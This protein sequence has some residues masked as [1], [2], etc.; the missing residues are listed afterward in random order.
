MTRAG[1]G[2]LEA[3]D[4]VDVWDVVGGLGWARAR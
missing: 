2:G 4:H 3:R 1:R